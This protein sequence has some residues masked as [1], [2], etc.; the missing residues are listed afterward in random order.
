[1]R[2]AVVLSALMGLA[3]AEVAANANENVEVQPA[4]GQVPEDA[5]LCCAYGLRGSCIC[6]YGVCLLIPMLDI[7][8]S[9]LSG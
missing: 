9:I 2:F 5:Q 8:W 6:N 4:D 1:M 3:L 7:A